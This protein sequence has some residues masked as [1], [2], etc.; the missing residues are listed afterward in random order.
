MELLPWF[1]SRQRLSPS[2]KMKKKGIKYIR[3]RRTKENKKIAAERYIKERGCLSLSKSD[4][5]IIVKGSAPTRVV[6][7]ICPQSRAPRNSLPPPH[8]LVQRLTNQSTNIYSDAVA[9][10]APHMHSMS[11]DRIPTTLLKWIKLLTVLILWAFKSR[12]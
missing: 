12:T 3:K 7:H 4:C 6:H 10:S 5:W 1:R 11:K 8:P 2:S 9:A